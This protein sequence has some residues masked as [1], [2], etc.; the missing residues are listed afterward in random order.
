MNQQTATS[1]AI[2]VSL[3]AAIHGLHLTNQRDPDCGEL[4]AEC[5]RF[6][7]PVRSV[8]VETEAAT[9]I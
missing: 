2:R 6:G 9:Q 1:H 8:L 5:M 3:L 4:I 7:I